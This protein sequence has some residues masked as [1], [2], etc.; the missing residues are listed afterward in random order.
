ACCCWCRSWRSTSSCCAT[1]RGGCS[2]SSARRA[3]RP[4]GVRNQAWASTS[5]RSAQQVRGEYVLSLEPGFGLETALDDELLVWLSRVLRHEVN[6]YWG[7][8]INASSKR[9]LFSAALLP[10][11]IPGDIYS[12]LVLL[13]HDLA[14]RTSHAGGTPYLEIYAPLRIPGAGGGAPR[15]F[16]SLPLQA[17]QQDLQAELAELRRRALLLTAAVF[18]VAAALGTRLAR[19]FTPPIPPVVVAASARH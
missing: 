4:G 11:R 1:S 17:Q 2:P 18:L 13:R 14:W 12:R 19:T 10:E 16:L 5:V 3:R 7:S 15:L 8:T 6:L 9:E